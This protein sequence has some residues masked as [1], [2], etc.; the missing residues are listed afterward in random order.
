MDLW[1]TQSYIA[2]LQG[3]IATYDLFTENI[4]VAL[5]TTHIPLYLVPRRITKHRLLKIIR[6]LNN[7]LKKDF[8]VIN[9]K[10]AMLSINPHGGEGGTIGKEEQ[11]VLLPAMEI[12][13]KKGV[14]IS[15]AFAADGFFA[16]GEYMHYDSILSMYHDQGL[17]A[18]KFFSAGNGGVN[19][20]EL[21][22]V[23]L[24]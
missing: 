1:E 22:I 16:H 9:P 14:C 20:T 4:R 3:K 18:L 17:T 5:V 7:S 8:G 10:I 13:K 19:F 24:T 23:K 2:V 21:P 11:Q 15:G 6:L 12:M